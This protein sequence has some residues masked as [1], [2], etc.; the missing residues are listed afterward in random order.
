MFVD[1]KAQGKGA[2]SKLIGY[3]KNVLYRQGIE[4]F[5]LMTGKDLPAEKFYLKNGF[6][7][8]ESKIVMNYKK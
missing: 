4:N 3:V 8:N 7:R 1:T 5:L 2:G 6:Y